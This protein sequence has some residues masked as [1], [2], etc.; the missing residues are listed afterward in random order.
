MGGP[1]GTVADFSAAL[2]NPEITPS[3]LQGEG[4]PVAYRE[5]WVESNPD[6]VELARLVVDPSCRNRGIGKRLVSLLL[7]ACR[8]LPGELAWIRVEPANAVAL[9]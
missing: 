5:L 8:S 4:P 2:A 9:A 3:L 6:E 7:E 1:A